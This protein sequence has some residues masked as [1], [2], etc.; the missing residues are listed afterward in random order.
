MICANSSS[1]AS[2]LSRACMRW[3]VTSSI[4]SSTRGDRG[5]SLSS[6]GRV[7][8]E[9]ALMH[10][11][12][13]RCWSREGG[14][15]SRAGA[16]NPSSSSQHCRWPPE[17]SA[18]G[19]N[20]LAG[21]A[22]DA[23]GSWG[24][25]PMYCSSSGCWKTPGVSGLALNSA[26]HCLWQECSAADEE[27]PVEDAADTTGSSGSARVYCSPSG[28]WS[29]TGASSRASN[30]WHNRLLPQR[31]AG[32][33]RSPGDEAALTASSSGATFMHC[34]P[35]GRWSTAEGSGPASNSAHHCLWPEGSARGAKRPPEEAAGSSGAAFMNC[36]PSGRSST[37]GASRV[38]SNSPRHCRCRRSEC[39]AGGAKRPAEEATD[40]VSSCGGT[41]GAR[42]APCLP[43]EEPTPEGLA[44]AS[45]A[46]TEA[47]RAPGHALLPELLENP[48]QGE[49]NPSFTPGKVDDRE[50]PT[51]SFMAEGRFVVAVVEDA[52]SFH[53]SSK[54]WKRSPAEAAGSGGWRALSAW[55]G[56]VR[57]TSNSRNS[58]R[59]A[60][61]SRRKCCTA[62]CAAARQSP[63]SAAPTTDGA[64][65]GASGSNSLALLPN[66]SRDSLILE[67]SSVF[68]SAA[69]SQSSSRSFE[70]ALVQ[71][72]GEVLGAGALAAP[73]AVAG[74]ALGPKSPVHFWNGDPSLLQA[75]SQ[76][77]PRVEASLKEERLEATSAPVLEGRL[78]RLGGRVVPGFNAAAATR[79]PAVS[80]L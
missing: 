7:S 19:V 66:S 24:A 55:P 65:R 43:P 39:S 41:G 48:S 21:E 49:M 13:S 6:A 64:S 36:S 15:W 38:A 54:P 61:A 50:W 18:A 53:A 40:A 23:G 5:H 31:S 75:P 14:C 8:S 77:R 80:N 47:S 37:T 22:T 58:R 52:S 33:A 57:L 59:I 44:E 30:S 72:V 63:P 1:T 25:A 60:V 68:G 74:T 73:L 70:E 35:S 11:S 29:A 17:S 34:S 46:P 79:C 76:H 9:A 27:G 56:G 20:R 78:P 26:G 71:T 42:A 12:P 10:C 51:S 4:A 67:N 28:H 2:I 3:R 32:G 69:A 62:P 45:C 16:S